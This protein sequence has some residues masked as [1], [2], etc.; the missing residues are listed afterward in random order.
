[1]LRRS[2]SLW[3]PRRSFQVH[4]HA[5]RYEDA[6]VRWWCEAPRRRPWRGHTLPRQARGRRGQAFR[7][8]LA[9]RNDPLAP[10]AADAP[11]LTAAVRTGA[12]R[13]RTCGRRRVVKVDSPRSAIG[14]ML[15]IGSGQ[16]RRRDA[17]SRG[18]GVNA[19]T[20]RPLPAERQARLHDASGWAEIDMPISA[21]STIS[22]R[23][24]RGPRA[25]MPAIG[26]TRN[27]SAEA[28]PTSTAKPPQPGTRHPT[29]TTA[30]VSAVEGTALAISAHC[31]LTSPATLIA[32][33]ASQAP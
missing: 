25:V 32:S 18:T 14:S 21:W 6:E 12:P 5:P 24:W 20:H 2:R 10:A 8:R 11:R 29:S 28:R 7:G 16:P 26:P 31:A 17:G 1:M 22:Q 27:R 23:P 4:A 30:W 3:L 13:G 15:E 9:R 33:P 19:A